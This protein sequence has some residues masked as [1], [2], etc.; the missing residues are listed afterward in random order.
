MASLSQN[1]EGNRN[2]NRELP[3][4]THTK[5]AWSL[6]FTREARLFLTRKGIFKGKERSGK[7]RE[8]SEGIQ[9]YDTKILSRN[10]PGKTGLPLWKRL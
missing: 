4:D 1:G 8:K 10:S 5:T 2:G 6:S 3:E 9:I 7:R